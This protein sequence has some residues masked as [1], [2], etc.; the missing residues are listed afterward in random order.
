[1]HEENFYIAN[2]RC[3]LRNGDDGDSECPRTLMIVVIHG[4]RVGDNC[5]GLSFGAGG[6]KERGGEKS[7]VILARVFW[8][9]TRTP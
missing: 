1:M 7:G 3:C 4:R 6:G 2:C 5:G 9:R 8:G